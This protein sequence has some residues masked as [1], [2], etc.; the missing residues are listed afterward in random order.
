MKKIVPILVWCFVISCAKPNPQEQIKHISGY[1]E[2]ERVVTQDGSQKKYNFNAS[3][4]FFEIKDSIGIRK[5]VQPK[6]DGSFITTND[7]KTFTL[8]IEND[9]LRMFYSTPISSW[10]ETIISVKENQLV[11]KNESGNVYF[12]TPYEKIQL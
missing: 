11:I 9:S 10:Q 8:K 5:K 4:D 2:I 1:W 3:I 6:L 12:Y 7:S